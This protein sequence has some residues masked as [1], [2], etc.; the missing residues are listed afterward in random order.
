MLSGTESMKAVRLKSSQQ[1]RAVLYCTTG[2]A[3]VFINDKKHK[4]ESREQFSATRHNS[5]S[6]L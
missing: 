3:H 4:E 6:V 5:S 1:Y 2:H